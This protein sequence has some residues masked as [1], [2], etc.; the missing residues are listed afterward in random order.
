MRIT[1]SILALFFGLVG[2]Y[3]VG[4]GLF[5]NG[6]VTPANF[7]GLARPLA[8]G[9]GVACLVLGGAVALA[10]FALVL[11]SGG[12]SAKDSLRPSHVLLWGGTFS[13]VTA[14]G[15]AALLYILWQ[16]GAPSKELGFVFSLAALQACLGMVLAGAAAIVEKRLRHI[17]VPVF[18]VGILETL[19][20]GGVMAYG[21]VA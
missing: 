8:N 14:A 20:V 9:N 6:A 7:E 11:V 10:F 16:R 18:A 5:A 1:L 17:T 3:L 13:V 19:L 12:T 21:F 15:F 2:T 4:A